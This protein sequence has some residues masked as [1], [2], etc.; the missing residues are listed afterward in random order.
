LRHGLKYGV[1]LKKNTEALQDYDSAIKIDPNNALFYTERAVLRGNMKQQEQAIADFNTAILLDP[2]HVSAYFGR[3]GILYLLGRDQEAIADFT[4]AINLD[5][6]KT[7][8]I[9]F[10]RGYIYENIKQYEAAI[11]DFEQAL[12]IAPDYQE[13][14]DHLDKCKL[15]LSRQTRRR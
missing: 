8:A 13:A 12:A 4:S 1:G 15:L 11:Q 5:S 3:G 2:Y 10:Y 7:Y 14:Q 9:Y 6:D